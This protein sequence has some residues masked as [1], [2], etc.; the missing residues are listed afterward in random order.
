MQPNASFSLLWLF[1]MRM[2]RGVSFNSKEETTHLPLLG[3]IAS[4]AINQTY[5][6]EFKSHLTF[7][8][9]FYRTLP[10]TW[11]NIFL[12]NISLEWNIQM[13]L[14][15]IT[16]R[17]FSNLLVAHVFICYIFGDKHSVVRKWVD[18][19]TVLLI[20]LCSKPQVLK[21]CGLLF[22]TAHSSGLHACCSYYAEES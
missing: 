14:M 17:P 18:L 22:W 6:L 13:K 1:Q 12:L 11:Q 15:R 4:S 3:S 21:N 20:E 2:M 5:F 16:S 7:K 8:L 10:L 9:T 19:H